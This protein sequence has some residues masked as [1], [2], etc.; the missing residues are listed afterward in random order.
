MREELSY[1]DVLKS[2]VTK[3]KVP[4]P[5]IEKHFSG[6]MAT[7]WVSR[8]PQ[9]CYVLNKLNSA[10]GLKHI[11]K[12]AEYKFIKS[13]IKL[14]KNKYIEFDKPDKNMNIIIKALS[15]YFKCGRSTVEEYMQILGGPKI[16]KILELL[17]Q[18]NNKYTT[19]KSILDIRE[20]L[21][22]KK[23][24]LMNIKGIE[25]TKSTKSTKG[26]K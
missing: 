2:I 22:K 24:D 20:A 19:D 7:S 9:S 13:M 14:P 6:F 3:K 16:I 26:T 25:N 12:L 21:L 15:S 8:D 5:D 11:P 18:L 4:V 23:E 17:A 1:F 10:Q